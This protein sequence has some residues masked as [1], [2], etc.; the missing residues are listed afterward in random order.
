LYYFKNELI[1]V[2]VEC[3]TREAHYSD[4]SNNQQPKPISRI[5][6]I[7]LAFILPIRGL[8][9]KGLQCVFLRVINL[10]SLGLRIQALNLNFSLPKLILLPLNG[11]E[12]R[13]DFELSLSLLSRG[14][15]GL[16][17]NWRCH[18][19]TNSGRAARSRMTTIWPKPSAPISGG[20]TS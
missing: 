19:S 13:E 18:R 11:D 8:C 16:L 10:F 7:M 6:R 9:V 2:R 1:L 5:L 20:T 4:G 17:W 12:L 15:Y 14:P 3:V